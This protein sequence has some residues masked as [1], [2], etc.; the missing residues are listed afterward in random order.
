MCGNTFRTLRQRPYC[1]PTPP[2]SVSYNKLKRR[3][4]GDPA[5]QTPRG[6]FLPTVRRISL[7][8]RISVTKRLRDGNEFPSRTARVTENTFPEGFWR[9]PA[10]PAEPTRGGKM[11]NSGPSPRGRRA[12]THEKRTK[13]KRIDSQPGRPGARHRLRAPR[14][15]KLGVEPAGPRDAHKRKPKEKAKKRERARPPGRPT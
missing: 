6:C 13:T 14:I 10:E 7:R 8:G 15:R 1:N 11:E 3:A 9:R 5:P 2:T 12:S 4:F